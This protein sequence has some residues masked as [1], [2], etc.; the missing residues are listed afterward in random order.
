MINW[1]DSIA[2]HGG[3]MILL[4]IVL[5][6][7]IIIWIATLV[8]QA[9]RKKW[10]WFILTLILTFLFGIGFLM[11]LIYWIVWLASPKSKKKKKKI[12]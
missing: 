2:L 11:V 7:G 4:L 10:A 6:I 5:L 3:L 8:H 12:R 1:T 9:K